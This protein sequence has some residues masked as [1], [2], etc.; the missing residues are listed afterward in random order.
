MIH[1]N[2][3]LIALSTAALCDQNFDIFKQSTK[4]SCIQ[5]SVYAGKTLEEQKKILIEQAKQESLEE[6]YG[7]LIL[8]SSDISNGKL[9]KDEI[10]SRAVGSVRVKGNP[11]FYNGKN[12]G[13]VCS[14]VTSYITKE[15]A[16][17]YG[18]KEIKLKNFCYT[19]TSISIKDIKNKAR[20]KVFQEIITQHKPSMS[21]LPADQL[22]QFIH[23]Y[24][25]T[26]SNFDFNKSSYCF[27][28]TALIMP[29]ELEMS[30][31]ATKNNK[32]NDINQNQKNINTY[33]KSSIAINSCQ[34][35][36][37]YLSAKGVATNDSL[38]IQLEDN[39]EISQFLEKMKDSLINNSQ[40]T[41]S[42]DKQNITSPT[43]TIKT[44]VSSGQ[45]K[46]YG[47]YTT[48][49]SI[50]FE[51]IINNSSIGKITKKIEASSSSDYSDAKNKAF[52][53]FSNDIDAFG[54]FAYTGLEK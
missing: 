45:K 5:Q 40:C 14:N 2:M 25:E 8:S 6:L 18:T 54:F 22:E 26:N 34:N 1:K 53:K 43:V 21:S 12:F 50:T 24:K 47:N 20:E 19:D 35:I 17:R 23:D 13:E 31:S 30:Q 3:I 27:D 52:E 11:E 7:T 32:I 4:E 46:Q 39:K 10:K 42:I 51:H 37:N 9:I 29:Y 41:T 16:E 38:T 49:L 36:R 44:V 33:F 15:D 48:N 28:A